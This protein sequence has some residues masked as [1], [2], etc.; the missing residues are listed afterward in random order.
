M[1][2]LAARPQPAQ[3]GQGGK[4][5]LASNCASI[6]A[7]LGKENDPALGS[8]TRPGVSTNFASLTIGKREVALTKDVT[9]G[10]R[11]EI[12]GAASV[13]G[14]VT[15]PAFGKVLRQTKATDMPTGD[16]PSLEGG[17]LQ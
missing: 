14:T 13:K 11:V 3:R 4:T 2:S 17:A 1:P 9:K 16:L 10:S 12:A 6:L 15:V 7:G 5:P 8:G